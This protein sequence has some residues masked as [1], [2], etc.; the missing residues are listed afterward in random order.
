ML[1]IT[2]HSLPT[3]K[4]LVSYRIHEDARLPRTR[5]SEPQLVV[6]VV[7]RQVIFFHLLQVSRKF[8]VMQSVMR[9]VVEHVCVLVRKRRDGIEGVRTIRE[10]PRDDTV[11]P[12]SGE[13]EMTQLREWV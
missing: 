6:F 10:R 8:R 5:N 1:K 7:V 13:E 11:S 4:K 2:S 12:R 3:I 9:A